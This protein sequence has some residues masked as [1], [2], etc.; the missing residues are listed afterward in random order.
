[1][2]TA[3]SSLLIDKTQ[4]RYIGLLADSAIRALRE[5]LSFSQDNSHDLLGCGK[6]FLS[7]WENG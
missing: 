3:E 2:V 6:I 5:R 1:M 7:C 4:A